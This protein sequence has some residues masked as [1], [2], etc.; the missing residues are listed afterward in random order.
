MSSEQPLRIAW[1]GFHLEGIPALEAL[2]ESGVRLV[3]VI[4]LKEEAL[5]R[6]SAGADYASVVKRFGVPLHTV[7]DINSPEAVELLRQMAPDVVFVIGWSQIVRPEALNTARIGM[8]G[9][10][11]SLLPHNRGSAPINWAI[12]HGESLTGNSLIWLADS[13]DAGDLIDQ[14]EF[15]ITP[16]DTCQTL[17][18]RVAAA[19]R[20]MI[21]RVTQRLLA[22]ERPGRPQ[23]HTDEP[24]LPRRRPGDGLVNWTAPS[25]A[26]YDF[27]RALTQPYPGA[28]SY[29]DGKRWQ[30]WS[31]ALLPGA[32][33]D[34]AAQAG[35][36]LGPVCSPVQAACGQLVQC[37]R[38]T[39]LL[40]EVEGP[41]G[42]LLRGSALADC[43]WEGKVWRN[44]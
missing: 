35:Q 20:E 6:R 11:A 1:I 29:L 28:F 40:L 9:A 5:A 33:G 30:I 36:A 42:E 2:L 19:N 22:G 31:C 15:R 24:V 39:A 43:R 32:L 26:V 25:C 7:A 10:H 16:Y 37:G 17:Y 4:T 14:Q 34:P 3:G 23:A 8:I 12:I 38:G 27:V 41:D 18:E 21:L 44:E 13:V